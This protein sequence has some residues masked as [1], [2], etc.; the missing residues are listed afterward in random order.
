MII[1][2][3][4][5]HYS[6]FYKKFRQ[7]S[8]WNVF[9]ESYSHAMGLKKIAKKVG[10]DYFIDSQVIRNIKGH[11][12]IS[13]CYKIKSKRSCKMTALV[14]KDGIPVSFHFTD[15]KTNF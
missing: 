9:E 4:R 3:P 1:G 6:T 12:Q 5:P 2:P 10:F 13:H 8:E 11:D 7:W 15:S 14:N